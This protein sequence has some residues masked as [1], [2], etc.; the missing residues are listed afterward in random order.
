VWQVAD[1]QIAIVITAL[2]FVGWLIVLTSTFLFEERDLIDLFGDEYVRYRHRVSML[3]P[4]RKS[5]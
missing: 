4:W 5:V 3:V 1:P 2:S